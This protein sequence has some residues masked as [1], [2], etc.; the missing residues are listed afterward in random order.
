M[1]KNNLLL[2]ALLSMTLCSCQLTNNNTS[3]DYKDWNT[4]LIDQNL[5]KNQDDR[6][7]DYFGYN[8]KNF[9]NEEIYNDDYAS[10]GLLVIKQNDDKIGFYSLIYN[11]WLVSPLPW[12][13]DCSYNVSPNSNVGFLLTIRFNN[14]YYCYDGLGNT[15]YSESPTSKNIYYRQDT[16]NQIYCVDNENTFIHYY[17]E[18][19]SISTST[20]TDN[21]EIQ[22]GDKFVDPNIKDEIEG[23]KFDGYQFSIDYPIITVYDDNG[24]YKSSYSLPYLLDSDYLS[25][26]YLAGTNLIYQ[27]SQPVADDAENYDY[28]MTLNNNSNIYSAKKCVL[29]S[30]KF[31]LINGKNK[32][33][34]LNYLIL[35]EGEAYKDEKG[36]FNYS[37]I[38][39]AFIGKDKTIKNVGQFLVD[40]NGKIIANASGFAPNSFIKLNNGNYYN[41]ENEILY[42]SKLEV[43][44]HLASINPIYY[45]GIGF[46]GS[47]GGNYGIVGENGIISLSFE[48]SYISEYS[49]NDKVFAIKNNEVYR[50]DLRT[51]NEEYIAKSS[52]VSKYGYGLYKIKNDNRTTI[53]SA[54]N[55][56]FS[57]NDDLYN[58]GTFNFSFGRYNFFYSS[59]EYNNTYYSISSKEVPNKNLFTSNTIN[60][61]EE[62]FE[63]PTKTYQIINDTTYPFEFDGTSYTSTNHE[64]NSTSSLTIISLTNQVIYFD[65]TVSSEANYDNL[66]IYYNSACILNKSGTEHGTFSYP[67]DI[68]DELIIT[69]TKDGSTSSYDD[70]IVISNIQFC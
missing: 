63:T 24:N 54:S 25:G 23:T 43:I 56:I 37:I 51:F 40:E 60:Y 15:I 48:Y 13:L 7:I 59:N 32:E 20:I 66:M 45:R 35:N 31:D 50:I 41:V 27:I 42:N 38:A 33:I 26:L 16:N 10:C 5:L 29:N 64:N 55:T 4:K 22:A 19:G 70:N 61:N 62:D 68:G 14:M 1:K 67:L 11:D 6:S 49:S 8:N 39:A 69:Y 17:N 28:L 3:F 65:Y 46:I 2:T 9:N 12:R 44:S 57:T 30:Y 53:C 52:E 18:N 21:N 58:T 36:K 47:M 34:N